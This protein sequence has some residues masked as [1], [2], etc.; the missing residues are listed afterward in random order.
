M[1]DEI[2]LGVIEERANGVTF[3]ERRYTAREMREVFT[4]GER[5]ELEAG[6]VI[7]RHGVIPCAYVSATAL[8]RAAFARVAR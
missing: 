6:R 2:T 1:A 7:R 3:Y 4:E 8:A 5:T